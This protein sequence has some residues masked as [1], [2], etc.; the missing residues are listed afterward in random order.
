MADDVNIHRPTG[1]KS[2]VISAVSGSSDVTVVAATAKKRCRVYRLISVQD[3]AATQ[4][5]KRGSTALTGDMAF[6][7]NSGILLETPATWIPWFV[8]GI[9]EALVISRGSACAL[10]GEVLY[11]MEAA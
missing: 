3:A 11:S 6:G 1:L 9:N 10:A 7:A 4:T 5:V 2:A 8:T